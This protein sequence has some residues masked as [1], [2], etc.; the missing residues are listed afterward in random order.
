VD[1]DGDNYQAVTIKEVL[2]GAIDAPS[3]GNRARRHV[4]AA[5]ASRYA[6]GTAKL[7]EAA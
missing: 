7:N 5:V 1:V 4:G 2:R 3:V 6:D